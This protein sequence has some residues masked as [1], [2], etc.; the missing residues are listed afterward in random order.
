MKPQELGKQIA[1]LRKDKGLTQA[2]LA[3]MCR[4][5]IRSIQR[6]ESGS[7]HP[8]AYTLRLINDVLGS[9]FTNSDP[10]IIDMEVKEL[11]RKFA[12]RKTIRIITF[13]SALTFL[14]LVGFILIFSPGGR[15]LGV[16]KNQWT[17]FV[18]FIMFAHIIAL[19]IY[20]RCPGC[21]RLLGD[22]FNIRFCSHCGLKL[23]D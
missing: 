22:V 3:D 13:V 9:N 18:Y 12:K 11:R 14:V 20:W 10:E 19:G 16:A 1:D 8:R 23:Y 7:V 4:L 17:P 21:N 15:L 6:L 5:N 2:E